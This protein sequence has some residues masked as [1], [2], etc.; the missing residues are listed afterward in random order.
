MRVIPPAPH[1]RKPLRQKLTYPLSLRRTEHIPEKQTRRLKRT[2]QRLYKRRR[3]QVEGHGVFHKSVDKYSGKLPLQERKDIGRI[4]K[5]H[6]VRKR[7][8]KISLLENHHFRI[9]FNDFY[10]GWAARSGP[11]E[12]VHEA[13]PHANEQDR[14][15]FASY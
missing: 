6:S 1:H 4:A 7:K 15:P 11:M 14:A 12:K 9:Y 5:V 2:P 3:L 13:G 8:R 10:P